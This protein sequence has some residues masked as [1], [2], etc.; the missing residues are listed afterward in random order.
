[1]LW[2]NFSG[3]LLHFQVKFI[4]LFFLLCHFIC[5]RIPVGL[6]HCLSF[7]HLSRA[8]SIMLSFRKSKSGSCP[9]LLVRLQ[10]QSAPLWWEP[11]VSQLYPATLRII[12]VYDRVLWV[13]W[14]LLCIRGIVLDFFLALL[15]FSG[16]CLQ[17]SGVLSQ[18][19]TE[20]SDEYHLLGLRDMSWGTLLLWQCWCNV[21]WRVPTL[22]GGLYCSEMRGFSVI[23][24][25]EASTNTSAYTH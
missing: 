13:I 22:L 3:N 16:F 9:L 23:F 25:S 1:M 7:W 6:I 18:Q 24:V 4:L 10:N 15:T 20:H 17:T 5:W 14:P 19:Y 11:L 21:I 12:K 2:Q 8:I